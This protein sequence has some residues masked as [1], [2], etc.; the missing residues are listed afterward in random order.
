MAQTPLRSTS[1]VE[2]SPVAGVPQR[3]SGERSEPERSGGTPAGAAP[4]VRVERPSAPD[5]EVVAKPRRRTFSAEYQIR[6][7][8]E[9]DACEPGQIGALLRRE[10]LYSS[11][12]TAWRRLRDKGFLV[13][14]GERRRGRK[15]KPSDPSVKRV[16]EL[17]RENRRLAE[18]LRK[19]QIIIDFQ[20]K[21]QAL[22]SMQDEEGKP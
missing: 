21:V 22:L 15:T 17:E 7:L 14:A 9:A 13:A 1:I 4:A 11:H 20:K 5:P 2:E 16:A 8:R 10:G 3:S 12:L 18:E 6:I 19:A